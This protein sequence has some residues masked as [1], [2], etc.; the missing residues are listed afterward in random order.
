M[1]IDAD[2]GWGS[3]LDTLAALLANLP[4]GSLVVEHGAGLYSTPLIARCPLRVIVAERDPGWAAWAQWMYESAGTTCLVVERAKHIKLD[5]VSLLFVDGDSSER[6]FLLDQ[7]LAARVPIIAAHDTQ[8]R[9]TRYRPHQFS[10]PGYEVTH[11]G[12]SP[13]TTTWRRL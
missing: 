12:K 8:D 11:D 5:G 13:Q 6:A 4:A 7:A 3:H 9:G 2:P 1:K 10:A